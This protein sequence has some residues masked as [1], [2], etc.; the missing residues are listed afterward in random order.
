MSKFDLMNFHTEAP[1]AIQMDLETGSNPVPKIDTTGGMFALKLD[2]VAN[3][4][5]TTTQEVIIIGQFNRG[6]ETQRVFYEGKYVAGSTDRPVCSSDNGIEPSENA[7]TPQSD[8]CATCRRN[9]APKG[10]PR[11]CSFFTTLAVVLPGGDQP[12]SL[13]VPATSM[14]GAKVDDEDFFSL[15]AYKAW[16]ASRGAMPFHA[17]TQLAF[18]RGAQKGYSFVPGRATTPEE[19]ELVNEA[20]DSPTYQAIVKG[21]KV[22]PALTTSPA[23]A[24]LAAPA[25]DVPFETAPAKETKS[26]AP[27]RGKSIADALASMDDD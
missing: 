6:S 9:T 13:R 7:Q 27:S 8:K 16:F 25:T 21:S 18:L 5:P 3:N 15:N 19:L 24:S 10:T 2:K 4:K 1:V 23:A 22:A 11:E 14:F 20:I 26:A 17:V 12:F